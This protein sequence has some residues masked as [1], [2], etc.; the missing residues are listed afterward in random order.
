MAN[1]LPSSSGTASAKLFGA[2]ALTAAERIV[3]QICQFSVF[4][5][6]ARILGPAEFGTYALVSACAILLLRASEVG[7][8]PYIMCWAGDDAVPRQVLTLAAACGVA[9]GVFGLIGSGGVAAFGMDHEIVVLMQLFSV[10]VTLATLSS[11]QKG[12]MIWQKSLRMSAICEIT[13]ELVGLCVSLATL[14]SG[15]GVLS[16]AFGRLSFQTTH[17]ILSFLVTRTWPALGFEA[18]ML[19]ELWV[20]SRHFFTSRMLANIKL[21][22]A[23]FIIGGALGSA[24][25]GYFR[26]AERLVGAVAEV[27]AVPAQLLGW[28]VFK[29]ARDGDQDA[30][31]TKGRI[32]AQLQSFIRLLWVISVPLFVWL[33]V[34]SD[35]LIEDLLSAEW[36]PAV[37]LVML[38]A[39]SR[40]LA[41]SGIATEPLLS[42]IGQSRQLPRLSFAMLVISVVTTLAAVPFGLH[43]VAWAQ[44]VAA[45]V[46]LAVTI[47]LFKRF[48]NVTL[49]EFVL[50]MRGLV[51][52]LSIGIAGLLAVDY[53]LAHYTGI[54]PLIQ[55][56][57]SGLVAT[58]IYAGALAVLA[59]D[60][61]RQLIGRGRVE[62]PQ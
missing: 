29:D 7:W 34:T 6:A 12:M 14:L 25:V 2:G 33:M 30:A 58:V 36:L 44:V 43:A 55:T 5:V 21:Y 23:T 13:G 54:P 45:V 53:L 59:R 3:A 10:W 49:T 9:F 41:T 47:Y 60:V 22:A 20:F 11:A 46:L 50:D 32:K 51:P 28:A 1:P 56:V 4:I 24:E 39:V 26:V 52:P 19:S 38:L 61:F 42:L 18:K 62:P 17:L 37:P 8:A 35:V 57:I 48:A 31:T 40:L 15:W 27:I 16:I